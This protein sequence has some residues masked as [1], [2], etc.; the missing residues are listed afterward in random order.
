MFERYRELENS[1]HEVSK[2][3]GRTVGVLSASATPAP[4]TYLSATRAVRALQEAW[5]LHQDIERELIPRMLCRNSFSAKSMERIAE[6]NQAIEKQLEA[7][8]SAPWPRSPQAGL[9]SIRMGVARV[10]T[11]I[12]AQVDIERA[13]VLPALRVRNHRSAVAA[14]VES[15]TSDLVAT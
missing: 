1:L 3:V 15:E 2:S 14:T 8:L 10:L 11:Q 13:V 4:E 9:H 7:I 12:L 6:S 5:S